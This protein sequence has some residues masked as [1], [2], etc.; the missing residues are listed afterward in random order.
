MGAPLRLTAADL[1]NLADALARLTLM[2]KQTGVTV[3]PH[4]YPE[5][6]IGDN[7]LRIRWDEDTTAYV[8]DDR[9]GD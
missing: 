3:D 8:I 2:R 1:N 6:G 5:I 4:T 7:A 9:N